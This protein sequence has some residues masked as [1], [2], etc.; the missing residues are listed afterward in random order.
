M[1]SFLTDCR[2]GFRAL[3]KNPGFAGVAALTL[4]LG[5]GATVAIFGV[6]DAV[7]VKPL[8][9]RDPERLVRVGFYHPVKNASGIGA[10]YM[11]TRDLRDRNRTLDGLAGILLSSVVLGGDDGASQADAAF[12]SADYFAT[13]GIRPLAGRLFR[14]DEDREGGDSHVAL[15]SKSLWKT[16]FGGERGAIGR[17]L[18]VDGVPHAVVGVVPDDEPLLDNAA[19][20]LPLVNQAFPNR[21]GRAVDVVGRLRPGVSLAAAR[22]DLGAIGEALARE[23]PED[24][25]AFSVVVT[26][27]HE[28]LFGARRPALAVLSGAVALLLLIACANTANLLLVRGAGRRRELAVRVALGA[29]RGRLARQLLAEAAALALVGGAGGLAVASGLLAAIRAA[30]TGTVERIGSATLDPR[31]LAFAG[32]ASGATVVLFGL[33]P[34]LS[35]SGRAVST[36][37]RSASRGGESTRVPNALVLVQTGLC[38]VL[39]VG[40]G[41]LAGS[42]ARL[43]R[44]NP[45]LSPERVLTAQ[46]SLPRGIYAKAPEKRTILLERIAARLRAMPGVRAAG[47]TGWLPAGGSMTMSFHP[48]G[49]PGLTRSASPQSELRDVTPGT[50]A[51]FGIPIFAGRDFTDADRAGG[52]PVAIVNRKLADRLWP[53]RPA[54]GRHVMLFADRLEREV[55]GVVGDVRRMD[56]RAEVPD[57]IYV[58]IAQAPLFIGTYAAVRAE[59]DP[60][61]LSAAIERAVHEIDSSVAVSSPRTMTDVLSKRV[62]EPRFRSALVG[63]FAAAALLLAAIGLYGVI[64]YAVTRRR[65]EIGVRVALGATPAEILRM[66]V[67]GGMRLAGAGAAIGL[68]GALAATRLLA[69]LLYGVAPF[70]VPTFAAAAALLL[71]VACLAT[72]VPARRAAGTDPGIA[73][74]AD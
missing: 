51:A 58:P 11:D 37:L 25:A 74:R 42:Y 18:L 55:V 28:S 29:G 15:L 33:L 52:T 34:A 16:R 8:P 66:F 56:R 19:V 40:A 3:G 71:G 69:G 53:G 32:A 24:D 27:L 35:A 57:Q 62:A 48:E 49:H 1:R 64:A 6:V 60:A 23:Y 41:L 12:V 61:A 2:H 44:T 45:G 50:F 9:Y 39:L 17:A 70:D 30:L 38:L 59:G 22:G 72:I 63:F 31:A 65:Y 13:L 7:L 14:A 67:G 43:S 21:S 4:S 73:L 26:P 47:L 54:L 5:I 20:V 10:S 68:V 36:R 46:L